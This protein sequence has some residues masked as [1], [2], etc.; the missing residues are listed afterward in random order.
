VVHRQ[1]QEYISK[2]SGHDS[3]KKEMFSCLFEKSLPLILTQ[4]IFCYNS[5]Y[6]AIVPHVYFPFP[7]PLK[8]TA[9]KFPKQTR[10]KNNQI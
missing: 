10:W 3:R 5:A 6:K 9:A 2:F 7:S 4:Q 8:C 1:Q